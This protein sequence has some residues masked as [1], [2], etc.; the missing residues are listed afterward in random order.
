MI[1]KKTI[2]F[3]A[4][5]AVP[6]CIIF[7]FGVMPLA[8]RA[9]GTIEEVGQVEARQE[10]IR[11]QASRAVDELDAI[12]A[13]FDD[14]DLGAQGDLKTLRAIRSVLNRLSDQDMV[15]VIGLLQAVPAQTDGEQ[16]KR[17][18]LDAYVGQKGIILQLR[19]LVLEFQSRQQLLE[20]S[21]RFTDLAER[22]NDNVRML[23][24]SLRP[25]KFASPGSGEESI[26]IQLGLQQAQQ[27]AIRDETAALLTKLQRLSSDAAGDARNEA[28][29]RGAIDDAKNSNVLNLIGRAADELVAMRLD[30]AAGNE[31]AAR[32]ELRTLARLLAPARD[33][34]EILHDALQ[35]LKAQEISEAAVM[36]QAGRLPPK[37]GTD[38]G[39]ELEDQQ[40]DTLDSIGMIRTDIASL[41]PD[42][43]K[44]L[45]AA[46]GK[47]Q[48]SR[49]PLLQGQQ[50]LAAIAENSAVHYL[51]SAE[52]EIAAT[53]EQLARDKRKD[54]IKADPIADAQDIK[55]K[56]DDLQET[57]RGLATQTPAANDPA[58]IAALAEKQAEVAGQ[59]KALADRALT[60]DPRAAASLNNAAGDMAAARDQLGK[61]ADIKTAAGEQQSAQQQ[62]TNASATLGQ[63]IAAALQAQKELPQLT[64]QSVRIGKMIGEE[65]Y[66]H[67]QTATLNAQHEAGTLTDSKAAAAPIA[68]RQ[69]E[70]AMVGHQIKDDLP[71]SAS[72]T[73]GA[74][75]DADAEQDRA[76]KALAGGL[77]ENAMH[78]EQK[79]LIAL[80]HA[81]DAVDQQI[82]TDQA[83]LNEADVQG[84]RAAALTA[85]QQAVD[86]ARA[87]IDAGADALARSAGGS[88]QKHAG[89][90]AKEANS[91]AHP[92]PM[93]EAGAQLHQVAE[94][95]ARATAENAGQV[96]ETV[97]QNLADATIATAAA[98]AHAGVGNQTAA[99]QEAGEAQDALESA[100]AAITL[101]LAGL[102]ATKPQTAS[103]APG[104]GAQQ[105]N[106]I[107]SHDQASADPSAIGAP[108]AG[109]ASQISQVAG[110]GID[111]NGR[112]DARSGGQAAPPG[113]SGFVALPPR[114]RQAIQQ[115]SREKYPEEYSDMIEQ[116]LKNVSDQESKK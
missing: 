26:R 102:G 34:E 12:I 40:V 111:G 116:Y 71:P 70:N 106:T 48:E 114:E 69:N 110:D 39:I 100:R 23:R 52:A 62:L 28:R 107:K 80:V 64:A 57:Q 36:D 24:R 109:Q 55:A 44:N 85:A 20:I 8:A 5:R 29:V 47:I 68:A 13:E 103:P 93:A 30:T 94:Q 32:D 65:A 72:E 79:A 43:A 35:R 38:P 92:S 76:T 45:D 95:L 105:A 81:K 83:K 9:A 84:A 14:S 63:Q 99:Q 4:F 19:Q 27:S 10:G 75:D 88:T 21:L 54:D 46:M 22:Q 98:A 50:D 104:D 51:K 17:T 77:V 53:I 87:Q 112:G 66:I 31:R 113:A 2:F 7:G 115:S 108:Q 25:Q 82:A 91:A 59:T 1:D 41:A 3:H 97:A 15:R 11:R 33:A 49:P 73:A 58:K 67:A 96:P 56:V 6:V 37:G 90:A 78:A 18:A 89:S 86:K 42:A 74:L 60:S 101:A 16:S 61:N